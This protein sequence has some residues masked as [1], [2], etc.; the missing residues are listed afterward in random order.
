MEYLNAKFSDVA[1]QFR[2]GH[3][4]RDK[5]NR[6]FSALYIDQTHKQNN[7]AVRGDGGVICLTKI[8]TL[9]WMVSGQEMSRIIT[10]FEISQESLKPTADDRQH[11]P[12]EEPRGVQSSFQSQVQSLCNVI[13]EKGNPSLHQIGN[14][15][16]LDTRDIMDATIVK[17]VRTVKELSRS[18]QVGKRS[19]T[20]RPIIVRLSRHK[21]KVEILQKRRVLKQ[22]ER[23]YNMQED[24]SQRRRDILK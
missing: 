8:P 1:T 13:R 12:K 22:N 10:E 24:L 16:L 5:T 4:V 14:F 6:A 9:F 18:H 15:L 23:P 3:F 17:T 2:K 20:P 19:S 11:Q 21:K 7:K